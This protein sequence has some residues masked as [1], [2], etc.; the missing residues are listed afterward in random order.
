MLGLAQK[1]RQLGKRIF[2]FRYMY[3]L[4]IPGLLYIIIFKYLPMF[5]LQVAFRDYHPADGIMGFFTA[6]WV[7]FENF[8]VLFNTPFA[9]RAI[10]N[11]VKISMLKLI[12][13]FPMPILLALIINEVTSK[14]YKKMVQTVTYLPHFFSWTI[15]SLILFEL[16]SQSTGTI[17]IWLQ[18][19]FD[20]KIN[21]LSNEK[22]FVPLLI[23]S[24][25]WK[26]VGWGSIIYLAA[27]AGVDAEQYEAATI[28]G[29]KQHQKLLYITIPGIL[30]TI[31]IMLLL[32]MGTIFDAGFEQIFLLYSPPVYSVADIIDTYVF[33]EGIN[34]MRYGLAT[35]A[36]LFKSVIA[37]VLVVTCNKIAKRRGQAGLY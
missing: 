32:K 21:F 35:A 8:E 10:W 4:L 6:E 12:F 16:L 18:N 29:A 7:G 19:S 9:K 24:D 14:R 33:R 27:L 2:Q 37:F 17:N 23:I 15:V 5:G 1:K 34:N 26:E 20:I 25:I 28:D 13:S 30:P 22:L 11:T 36:G 31:T 3:V